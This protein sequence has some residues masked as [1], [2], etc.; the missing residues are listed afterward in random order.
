ME[1]LTLNKIPLISKYDFLL[2]QNFSCRLRCE[3]TLVPT[4]N[5]YLKGRTGGGRYK[6]QDTF[7]QKHS[8]RE[9]ELHHWGDRTILK[10]WLLFTN[11][12]FKL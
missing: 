7:R 11:F 4:F 2:R 12:L 3:I 10:N 5:D 1:A 8:L 9:P 6:M